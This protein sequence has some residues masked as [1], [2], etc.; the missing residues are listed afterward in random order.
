MDRDRYVKEKKKHENTSAVYR[1]LGQWEQTREI[2]N[3]QQRWNETTK[4]LL[5][6]LQTVFRLSF[7]P[8]RV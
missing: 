8:L 7:Q 3:M 6:K 2:R 1:K 5:T 4:P